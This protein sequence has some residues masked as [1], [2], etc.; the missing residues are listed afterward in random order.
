MRRVGALVALLV[1]AGGIVFWVITIPKTIEAGALSPHTPDLA[2]G[3]IMFLAGGCASCHAPNQEDR[4][5]LAGGLA[6]KSPF[7]TFYSPNISPHPADGIGGWSE[8]D[9]LTAMWEGTS[10]ER[11]H[12]YPAFPYTSY[13]RMKEDDLR[14]LFAYLKTLPPVEGKGRDH[15]LP[16]PFRIRR[17]VGAWKFLFLDGQQF[18]PDPA[19]SQ[20]WN[21]GAYL[22]NGP[23]H[24]AECHSPRNFLGAIVADQRFAGGPDP[25]GSGGQ[26]PN[27]TQAGIGSYSEQDI[28]RVL[29]NGD[30]PDGD[31]VG[32]A[33][34]AV[35]RNTSELPAE[36]RDAIATFIKSLPPVAGTK[37]KP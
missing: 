12:Y 33:M 27:I 13:Q 36:D 26:I 18:E 15:D 24:C 6:L 16:L 32:G 5:R 1:I 35:V 8:A 14:D 25:E 4:S 3:R 29:E 19:R 10:P 34:R 9:F 23:S 31:S 37:P 20:R 22:V 17:L 30:L 21:R 28:Q 2:N 7:G 11:K